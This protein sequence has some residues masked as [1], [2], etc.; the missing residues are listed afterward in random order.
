M[1]LIK[2]Y[3][4]KPFKKIRFNSGF[5]VILGEPK[6]KKRLDR[7]THNLGKSFLIQV[8]DFLMLK[9]NLTNHV[10]STQRSA[11]PGYLFYLEIQLN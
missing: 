2:I 9:K 3:A 4:N 8:I 5:N 11:F 1:K 7:D 6:D 10:F